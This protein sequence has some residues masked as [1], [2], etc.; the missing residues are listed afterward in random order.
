MDKHLAQPGRAPNFL[1]LLNDGCTCKAAFRHVKVRR[2][3]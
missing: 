3:C 1:H 2:L